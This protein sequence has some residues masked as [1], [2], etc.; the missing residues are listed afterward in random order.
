MLDGNARNPTKKKKHLSN[1]ENFH[2]ER[3]RATKMNAL[4]YMCSV[5]FRI[6]STRINTTECHMHNSINKN[7]HIFVVMSVH[8]VCFLFRLLIVFHFSFFFAMK[9]LLHSLS[10]QLSLTLSILYVFYKHITQL[11]TSTG[12]NSHMSRAGSNRQTHIT[13]IKCNQ[14]LRKC[15]AVEQQQYILIVVIL[16]PA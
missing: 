13:S 2:D 5:A 10:L 12:H 4:K 16:S 11:R 9:I 1:R 3:S 6:V 15:R 14:L 7:F 8:L